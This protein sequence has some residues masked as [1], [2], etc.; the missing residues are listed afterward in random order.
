MII[1]PVWEYVRS[2]NAA[3]EGEFLRCQ[4]VRRMQDEIFALDR[5]NEKLKERLRDLDKVL[6]EI[7][8]K[9]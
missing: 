8:T 2:N 7:N 5:E 3:K 9:I 6:L 4:E 1:L